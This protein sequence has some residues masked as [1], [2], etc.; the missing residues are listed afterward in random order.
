MACFLQSTLQKL[1]FGGVQWNGTDDLELDRSSCGFFQVAQTHQPVSPKEIFFALQAYLTVKPALLK[2]DFI[3][4]PYFLPVS[5][6]V[7]TL[8]KLTLRYALSLDSDNPGSSTLAAIPS[9]PISL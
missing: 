5:V 6:I 4:I 8:S 1:F 3:S 9:F 2:G 7:T